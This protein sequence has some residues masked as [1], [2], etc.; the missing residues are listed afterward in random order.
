MAKG[1]S[2]GFTQQI[3]IRIAAGVIGVAIAI[4]GGLYYIMTRPEK[5]VIIPPTAEQTTLMVL[6]GSVERVVEA[7]SKTGKAPKTMAELPPLPNGTSPTVDGW[8]NEVML[9][10]TGGGS[11]YLAEVRS[12][13]PDGTPNNADDVIVDGVIEKDPNSSRYFVASQSQRGVT[14]TGTGG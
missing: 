11:R 2:G 13:G 3:D 6:N 1:S 5:P 4:F 8:N 14:E 7:L 10:V 12:K 9:K